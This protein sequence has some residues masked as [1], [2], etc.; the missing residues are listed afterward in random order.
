MHLFTACVLMQFLLSPSLLLEGINLNHKSCCSL[1]RVGGNNPLT[2]L[3]FFAPLY[4]KTDI[5]D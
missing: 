5:T 1:Q 2:L 4:I 3:K